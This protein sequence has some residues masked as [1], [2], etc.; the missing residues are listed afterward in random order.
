MRRRKEYNR[1]SQ[2]GRSS[3]SRVGGDEALEVLKKR[4]RSDDYAASSGYEYEYGV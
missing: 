4:T 2:P 1:K 3:L